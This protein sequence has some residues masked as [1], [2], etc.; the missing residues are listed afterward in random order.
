MER[1][2]FKMQLNPGNAEEYRRR[3]DTI[4]P[5][6]AALLTDSGIR[7]Y[8]IFLDAETNILFATLERTPDHRMAALPGDPVM[9]RWW[10][11]MRD[12]MHTNPDGSPVVTPLAEVFH[13]A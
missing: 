10:D 13:L 5:E 6:L 3:H 1:I 11:H 8:S 2:A 12:L 9:R 4:W 7:N